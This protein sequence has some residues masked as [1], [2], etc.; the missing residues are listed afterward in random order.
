VSW[1]ALWMISIAMAS[2]VEQQLR[3]DLS[4]EGQS[5]GHRDLK[6]K[7]IPSQGEM[8][9]IVES[10]TELEGAIGPV[11][12][13]YRQRL[14]AH[15]SNEPA[16]FHAVIDQNGSPSEV[17]ARYTVN[18]WWVTV[19]DA[20]RS[21]TVDVPVNR[22]DLS[23]A[24]LIDPES[25][26]ALSRFEKVRLLSAE[27]GDIWEGAVRD[28]G[29]SEVRVA[30]QNIPV[31]GYAWDGPQGTSKFYYSDEGYLVRYHMK[32]S[33]FGMEGVLAGPPPGGIDEFS[34]AVG[35]ASVEEID[36]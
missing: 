5:I 24:D 30:D 27:T 26:V 11:E 10:W 31:Q 7:F 1:L 13:R 20:G 14:T 22:I 16:S 32:M 2:P 23:T 6:I 12:L 21:R 25:R 8:L 28:L 15:A 19:A 4:V 33:G 34:V 9:R 18:G 36:L 29:A 3:W 17:Q 35:R